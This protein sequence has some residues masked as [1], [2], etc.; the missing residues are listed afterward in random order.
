MNHDTLPYLV[1]LGRQGWS[2]P[3]TPPAQGKAKGDQGLRDG[4]GA[5]ERVPP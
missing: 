1:N 3:L 2:V 5:L 4:V